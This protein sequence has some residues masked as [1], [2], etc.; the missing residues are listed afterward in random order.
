[1]VT[2]ILEECMD[3]L[4]TTKDS[5]RENLFSMASLIASLRGKAV[6]SFSSYD[7]VGERAVF[8][9]SILLQA[10]RL[11]EGNPKLDY[12]SLL[13]TIVLMFFVLIVAVWETFAILKKATSKDLC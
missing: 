10:H 5:L 11:L 2:I 6:L 9:S 8:P 13:S 1:M 4:K 12:S 7:V 3:S